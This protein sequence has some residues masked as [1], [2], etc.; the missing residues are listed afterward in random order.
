MIDTLFLYG[1]QMSKLNDMYKYAIWSKILENIYQDNQ[2]IQIL[3]EIARDDS[4]YSKDDCINSL[5]KNENIRIHHW[6][7]FKNQLE[8]Y[9]PASYIHSILLKTIN[10]YISLNEAKLLLKEFN[11]NS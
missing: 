3:E 1:L 5:Q 9:S 7:F 10:S 11:V 6:L 2:I 8:T 4:T